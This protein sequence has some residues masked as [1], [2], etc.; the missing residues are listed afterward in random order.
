MPLNETVRVH[1]ASQNSQFI[2]IFDAMNAPKEIEL[3]S[4]EKS[5]LTFGRATSNDIVLS[6]H[7]VSRQH[8]VFSL[9][10]RQWKIYDHNSTNGIIHKN[11]EVSEVMIEEDDFVRIDDGIESVS[12]GVLMI[13]PSK[14]YARTWES[15]P[16]SDAQTTLDIIAPMSGAYIERAGEHF[17]LDLSC[18][19]S[20][21]YCN[22]RK[23]HKRVEL[24][25][26][27]VISTTGY[28]M[29]FTSG[30]IYFNK[31]LPVLNELR[32]QDQVF[33]KGT[34]QLMQMRTDS[35][36]TSVSSSSVSDDCLSK[37]TCEQPVIAPS[38]PLSQEDGKWSVNSTESHSKNGGIR[39]FLAS[40]GGYYVIVIVMALAVWGAAVA[41]WTSQGELALV[42]MLACSIFGW[43]A[44]NR[45]Q[46]AMFIWMSWI[47]W[48]IYFSV[49]F[50][51]SALIGLFVAPFK[52]AKW[53]AGVIHTSIQ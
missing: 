5:E 38:N 31:L 48:L 23:V 51:L 33:E 37:S 20:D 42:V 34:A 30:V 18:T 36:E 13:F 2:Y 14:D 15:I 25:E 47:G 21:V 26:K 3:L 35:G 46:P 1:P 9:E 29:V 8:G 32:E 44:L 11:E 7:L 28:R 10:N 40:T 6:S 4:F 45:I 53:I 39:K 16:L 24:H 52:L 17:Y 49:K 27:D 19:P 12:D 43:K 41:L 22:H 50:I